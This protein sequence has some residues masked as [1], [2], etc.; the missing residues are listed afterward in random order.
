MLEYVIFSVEDEF[1]SSLKTKL[2]KIS[3]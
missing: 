1:P 3:F 2:G